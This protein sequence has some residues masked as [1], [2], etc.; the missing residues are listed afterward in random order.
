M[1]R[2]KEPHCEPDTLTKNEI[3]L[4]VKVVT[5]QRLYNELEQEIK[6]LKEFVCDCN[7]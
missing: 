4:A 7:K 2:I 5:Q 1:R 6:E 3:R